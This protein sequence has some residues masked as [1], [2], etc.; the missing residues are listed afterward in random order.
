MVNDVISPETLAKQ[1]I[2][3]Q[4]Y[5]PIWDAKK[6][7]MELSVTSPRNQGMIRK[8]VRVHIG[9]CAMLLANGFPDWR[10]IELR[11]QDD[12]AE[13]LPV[14]H[15]HEMGRIIQLVGD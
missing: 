14:D 3:R 8:A 6:A 1:L 11:A 15:L 7:P 10:R 12:H 9:R 5:L 2:W 4:E 13:R